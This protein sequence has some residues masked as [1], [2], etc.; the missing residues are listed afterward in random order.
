MMKQ[1]EKIYWWDPTGMAS[2]H[3]MDAV[4]LLEPARCVTVAEVIH[5]S[6][7]WIVTAASHSNC[8]GDENTEYADIT[9]IPKGCITLR[10][11]LE[12]NNKE[13]QQ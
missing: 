7:D 1:L 5:E 3:T 13:T 8:V 12:I 9:V 11:Q 6:A 2:W 10:Q 4:K